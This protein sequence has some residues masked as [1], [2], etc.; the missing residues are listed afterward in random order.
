MWLSYEKNL[1]LSLGPLLLPRSCPLD[2]TWGHSHSVVAL[3][4][5]S[6][7]NPVGKDI[8]LWAFGGRSPVF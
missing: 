4:T 5:G 8:V 2:D 3:L 7:T 6:R 1:Y